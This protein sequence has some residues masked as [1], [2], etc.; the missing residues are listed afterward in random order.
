MSAI[1]AKASGCVAG[2]CTPDELAQTLSGTQNLCKSLPAGGAPTTSAAPEPTVSA[3]PEPTETT[4]PEPTA[5][6]ESE[7]TGTAAPTDTGAGAAETVYVTVCAT[8]TT[9]APPVPTGTGVT[10][11]GNGTSPTGPASPSFTAGADKLAVGFGSVFALGLAI[12][13]L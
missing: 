13:A 8:E 1:T 12:L 3:G 10:P 5:T 11:P 9:P 7:P 2:A 6:S 4:G